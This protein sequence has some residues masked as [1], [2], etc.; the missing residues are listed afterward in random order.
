MNGRA[1]P[2]RAIMTYAKIPYTDEFYDDSKW[3]EAK[4]KTIKFGYLPCLEVDGKQMYESTTINFYL[5]RKA[6]LLGKSPEDEHKILELALS[7]EGWMCKFKALMQPTE[8]QKNNMETI[9]KEWDGAV[10]KWLPLYEKL[11]KENGGGKYYIGNT[12]T[13]ADIIISVLLASIL[14]SRICEDVIGKET[15]KLAPGIFKIMD[16]VK[17]KDLKEYFEKVHMKDM[18]SS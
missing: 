1:A 17:E 15:D 18:M 16:S 6:N 13:L 5:A 12:F 3:M 10:K 2:A 11:Y 9:K 8:E 4:N 7:L 14:R